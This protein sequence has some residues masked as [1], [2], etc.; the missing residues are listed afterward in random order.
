MTMARQ[1]TLQCMFKSIDGEEMQY[2]DLRHSLD[3][4]SFFSALNKLKFPKN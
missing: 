4:K 2:C 3:V 1:K